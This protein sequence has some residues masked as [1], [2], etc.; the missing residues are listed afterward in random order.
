MNKSKTVFV[1]YDKESKMYIASG[2]WWCRCGK[3][4]RTAR[5]EWRKARRNG[6]ES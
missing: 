2:T 5:A 6:E 3:T 1:A 4:R